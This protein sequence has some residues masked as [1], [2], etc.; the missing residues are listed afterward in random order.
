[1]NWTRL[2]LVT[3]VLIG[4]AASFA[5]PSAVADGTSVEYQATNLGG[6]M[7]QYTYTLEGTALG[8]NQA[9]SVLFDFT[10]TSNLT[11]TSTD[12]TNPSSLAATDW[13]SFVLQ[14][15]GSGELASD[16]VYT[17]LSLTGASGSTDSFTVTF[18]YLGSGAPG[19]QAFS[20]DQYDSSGDLISN[21]QT[22]QTVPFTSTTA[23]PEP[24]SGLLLALGVALLL[25]V[26]LRGR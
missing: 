5:A 7:W 11:D 8:V 15:S 24:E 21:V 16:G 26:A 1:M 2:A 22:G 14:G 20:I 12:A 17:A 13:A 6:G 10:S 19:S 3:A 25:G 9:F 4:F 18:D 23:V